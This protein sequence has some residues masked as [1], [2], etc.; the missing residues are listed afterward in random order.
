MS[1]RDFRQEFS[2][3]L[4]A[5]NG[6]DL[7]IRSV[8]SR[9]NDLYPT[10]RENLAALQNA[11]LF[12][13][14]ENDKFNMELWVK[15]RATG[16][17]YDPKTGLNRVTLSKKTGVSCGTTMCI[18]G[19]VAYFNLDDNE[20]LSGDGDVFTLKTIDGVDYLD[21]YVEMSDARSN[22]V[23]GLTYTQGSALYRLPNDIGVVKAALNYLAQRDLAVKELENA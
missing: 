12:A 11:Y 4:S 18:A 7:Y 9:V 5:Y 21:E 22:K 20:G 6:R 15:S 17:V 10:G 2:D 16:E 13:V 8:A 19:S 23:L 3:T 14:L 1:D